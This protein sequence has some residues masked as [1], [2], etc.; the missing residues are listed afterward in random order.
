VTLPVPA[1]GLAAVAVVALGLGPLAPA[2]PAHVYRF[3]LIQG[4]QSSEFIRKCAGTSLLLPWMNQKYR[5]SGRTRCLLSEGDKRI[6]WREFT[7][8]ATYYLPAP[9]G[10]LTVRWT[11]TPVG[12]HA[13]RSTF[14]Y[15]LPNQQGAAASCE[16]KSFQEKGSEWSNVW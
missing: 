6:G 5:P 14:A 2:R 15:C 10:K 4:N 7:I 9:I 11:L 3:H 1:R 13:A 12:Y 16:S 8:L